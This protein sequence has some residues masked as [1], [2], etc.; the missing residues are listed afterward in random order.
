[1]PLAGLPFLIKDN[2][3]VAGLHTTAGSL[4]LKDHIAKEDAPVVTALRRAG[5][6]ILGKTNMTEFANF[7][8]K[9]MRGGYSSRGGQVYHAYDRDR[10]PSGSSSGSAVALSAGLCAAA[11][12]TDTSFS[13]V[14]CAAEHGVCGFKPVMGAL[15]QQGI[16][17]ISRT[18]DSAGIMARDMQDVLIIYSALR[19]IP[20]MD[21]K[22]A[23]P[24]KMRLAIN[25]A[26]HSMTSKTQLMRY[27][28]LLKKMEAAGV[29]TEKIEQMPMLS[30]IQI[31]AG[32]F[33]PGLEK[34]LAGAGD[35]PETL[36]EIV[37]IYRADPAMTKYGIALLEMAL[38]AQQ[39]PDKSA[40][41]KA[42][43]EREQLRASVLEELKDFDACLVTGPTNVCHLAG[44]PSLSVPFCM[45]KD[46]LPCSAILYGTDEER[47]LSAALT[48]ESF[49][50]GIRPPKL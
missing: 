14:I 40:Y 30:Q 2:I 21:I 26:N 13:V 27:G 34:Y 17:P 23:E 22:P 8:A 29:K 20:L 15:S 33:G 47:L 50:T 7:T 18:M 16:I 31:M 39:D 38:N 25:T 24:A 48:I 28:R 5:A 45:G 37:E 1:G 4:A 11:L 43:E 32:E 46:G 9:G 36:K 12:G 35:A 41:E 10:D 3:D 19:G 44:I 42:M 49:S 6:V